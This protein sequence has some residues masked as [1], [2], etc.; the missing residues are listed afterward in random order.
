[1]QAGHASVDE[2]ACT[3]EASIVVA[4]A[5]P[6]LLLLRLVEQA[7]ADTLLRST[8][9][10]RAALHVLCTAP[11]QSRMQHCTCCMLHVSH[12][13]GLQGAL[14]CRRICLFW[15]PQNAL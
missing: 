9:G 1:M 10:A 8:P 7:A 14:L 4:L 6:R 11:A 2:E 5:A 3:C 12:V 15:A 13:S